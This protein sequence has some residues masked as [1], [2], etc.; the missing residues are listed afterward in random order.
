MRTQF[1]S[2]FAFIIAL[3]PFSAPVL[4]DDMAMDSDQSMNASAPM[5]EGDEGM[6]AMGDTPPQE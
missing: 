1:I 3:A 5:P 6:D 2:C 4:A